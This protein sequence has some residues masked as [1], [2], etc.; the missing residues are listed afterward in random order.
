MEKNFIK[1]IL[2]NLL[3]ILTL[4]M[5]VLF[6]ENNLLLTFILIIIGLLMLFILKSLKKIATFILC[7]F[8]GTIAEIIAIMSGAWVY[9]NPSIL[10]IPF[11]LI[12]LWGIAAIFMTNFQENL[13]RLW[14]IIKK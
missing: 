10:G 13:S 8:L 7:G 14:H 3:S 9:S 12:P 5:V 11:W 1:N 2:I 6:W 4:A